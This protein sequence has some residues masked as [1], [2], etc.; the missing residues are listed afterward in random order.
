MLADIETVYNAFI[1]KKALEYWLAPDGMTGKIH[2][3]EF[4][5]DGKYEK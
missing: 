1:D 5:V 2:D 3:F 4:K